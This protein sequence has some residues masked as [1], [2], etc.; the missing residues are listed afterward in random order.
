[1]ML[2]AFCLELLMAIILDEELLYWALALW[3]FALWGRRMVNQYRDDIVA[4]NWG[5]AYFAQ[6]H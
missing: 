3:L 2:F 6:R 5:R 4:R 1:M